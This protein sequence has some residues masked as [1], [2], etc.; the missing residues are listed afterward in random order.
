[1]STG[2]KLLLLALAATFVAAEVPTAESAPRPPLCTAGRFAVSGAPLLG[3]GGE[4]VVLENRTV[5]LGT[6]CPAR[7]ARLRRQKKGTAVVVVFPKGQCTG[8]NAK[9]RVKALIT[10]DCSALTGTLRTKGKAPA[11]F[12]AATSVCGDGVVDTGNNETCDGSATGCQAG[13]ACNNVCQCLP[14]RADKSSPIEITAGRPQG[15]G[16]Q[17]RHRHRVVLRGRRRRAPH[18]AR[19]R[20]PVGKEPRSVATLVEQAVGVRRQHRERHGVG[21]RPGRLLDGRDDRRRHRAVGRRRVPERPFVYVANANDNTVQV[22]DTTTNTVIATIPV[23]RSPRALAITNDGDADDLDE[24]LY[25]PNFFARPRAGFV[26][27]EQRQPGRHRR[28][29]RGLPDGRQ[30]AAGGRRGH[31]RRLARGRRRRHVDRDQRRRRP[32]GPRADGRHRL[33][34]R[35][36]RLRQHDAGRRAAHHLRRRRHRRHRRRSRPAR[37]RTCCRASRSSTAAA[38]S[39]TPPP[40]PSRRCASTSTCRAWS[41]CST[42]PPTASSPTRPST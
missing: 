26:A 2:S 33:Q 24:M 40:R 22:I 17:H 20:W 9:V 14:T 38:S 25:V 7:K 23:G 21:D 42:S 8:V 3:P 28:C 18:Q 35:P 39:P 1:M 29:R 31:L 6:L 36:R 13:E 37:S 30:R 15:R 5:A 10:D 11:D 19:R 32:G 27:A 41:R 34:L 16:G 4:V 12:D